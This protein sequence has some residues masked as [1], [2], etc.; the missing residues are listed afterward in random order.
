MTWIEGLLLGCAAG[1][2][3]GLWK[4]GTAVGRRL[5]AVCAV[6]LALLLGAFGGEL[7]SDLL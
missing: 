6:A 3:V 5:L 1:V 2:V 4:R 7:M